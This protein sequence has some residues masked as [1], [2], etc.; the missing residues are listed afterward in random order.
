MNAPLL[1]PPVA[2]KSRVAGFAQCCRGAGGVV[3]P[4]IRGARRAGGTAG[5]ESEG[6]WES[7]IFYPKLALAFRMLAPVVQPIDES[8]FEAK[9][10]AA[11]SLR[12]ELYDAPYYRLVHS[13]GDGLPGLIIDRFGDTCVLQVATAGMERLMPQIL[14]ALDA[15]GRAAHAGAAQ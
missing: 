7:G 14:A 11:L 2:G 5:C 12:E 1:G 3:R 4:V 8:F 10:R 15:T 13:E 9:L 6:V